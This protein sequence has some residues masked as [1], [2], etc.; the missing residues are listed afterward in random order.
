MNN[1]QHNIVSN[2]QDQL[3]RVDAQ[4]VSQG[5]ASKADCHDGDGIRHR[6]F[7]I[8]VFNAKGE[9]LLQQR[10]ANKRLWPNFWS[11]T[12][13][14]H[15][16]W[17]E[18]MATAVQRRL[19]EEMGL[20][21]DLDY[22]Y[23]FEYSARYLDLGSEHEVCH[24]YLGHSHNEPNP[25]LTEV[26]A[27][28]WVQPQWLDQELAQNGAAYTPWLHLEWARLQDQFGDRLTSSRLQS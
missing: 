8:F 20:S 25:N 27:W 17:E 21:T 5:H 6:A 23:K 19:Q 22:L 3:I 4:D 13:C 24:V 26:A 10:A 2:E 7:S 18:D 14:S 28:K 16:R 11:N 1:L 12:C 9:L 15:P